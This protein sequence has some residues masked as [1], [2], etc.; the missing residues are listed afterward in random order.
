MG[1]EVSMPSTSSTTSPPHSILLNDIQ[2]A[3]FEWKDLWFDWLEFDKELGT[4][5]LKYLQRKRQEIRL[6]GKFH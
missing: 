2:K 6:D 5:F 4:I 1:L 3:N